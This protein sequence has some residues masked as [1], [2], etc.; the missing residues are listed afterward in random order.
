MKQCS[1]PDIGVRAICRFSAFE[2]WGG[3]GVEIN[4]NDL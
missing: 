2:T 1:A 3:F 4:K